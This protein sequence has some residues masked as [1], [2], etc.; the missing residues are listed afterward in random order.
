MRYTSDMTESQWKIVQEVLKEASY[1]SIETKQ[2]QVN[3]VFY[4]V[5]TECQWRN[6]PKDF[7][8]RKTVYSFYR[9]ACLNGT[10]DKIQREIVKKVR[11][12]K[13]KSEKPTYALI[14]FQSAKTVSSNQNREYDGGKNQRQKTTHNN[15]YN[16]QHSLR[17]CTRCKYS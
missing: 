13:G 11:V 4:F 10:W 17:F 8:K 3:A 14:D 16:G 5:K 6:L 15:R 9:R 7:P 12:S 2:E 1:R